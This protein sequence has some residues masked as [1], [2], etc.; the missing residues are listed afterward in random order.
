MEKDQRLK[1]L[2]DIFGNIDGS[3]KELVDRLI[4]EVVFLEDQMET[5]KKLPF[6]AQNP[7]NPAQM[8]TTPAAKL[9]KETS[10]SYMNAVRILL[11]VLRKADE[12]E[13]NE[14]LKRLEEFM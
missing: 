5:L 1:A 12:T 8:K 13:E 14:L 2:Q 10:Q 4:R 9:Y 6:I 11:S 7:K 3:E